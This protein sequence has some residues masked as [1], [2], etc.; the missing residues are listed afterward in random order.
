MQLVNIQ[1]TKEQKLVIIQNAN[2][3]GDCYNLIWRISATTGQ[4]PFCV[5]VM[6]KCWFWVTYRNSWIKC[7]QMLLTNKINFPNKVIYIWLVTKNKLLQTKFVS[8]GKKNRKKKENKCNLS[9]EKERVKK[10]STFSSS[11]LSLVWI[12]L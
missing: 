2:K 4:F 6:Q 3:P 11:F 7:D 10:K 12:M 9:G 8:V 1:N 5:N